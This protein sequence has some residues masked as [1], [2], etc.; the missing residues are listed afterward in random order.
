[1]P[2]LVV[3][4]L[5]D[6]II[7]ALKARAVEHHRSTEAEH[8]AILAEVLAK[9]QRKSLAE[10]LASIPDAGTDEDFQRVNDNSTA[11]NVFG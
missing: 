1:M 8:R 4:N 10:A 3:R 7:N 5:D 6:T 9:P 2:S 11:A